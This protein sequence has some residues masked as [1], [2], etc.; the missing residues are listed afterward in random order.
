[1][2]I[3]DKSTG[4]IPIFVNDNKENLFLVVLH[5][6]GHWAFPKGHQKIGESDLDTAKRELY[7]ETGVEDVKLKNLKEF[8]EF[9]SFEKNGKKYDKK[10][11]YFIGFVFDNKTKT[12]NEFKHE[13]KRMKWLNYS[14]ALDIITFTESRNMLNEVKK[15]LEEIACE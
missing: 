14:E 5:R 10:V 15:Y 1:M 3:K 4:I 8:L 12:P 11:K 7:E 6:D 13:I 2:G 9:Y